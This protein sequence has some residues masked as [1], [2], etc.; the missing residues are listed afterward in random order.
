[1]CCFVISIA[2][3]CVVVSKIFRG[4]VCVCSDL[5]ISRR[6][7]ELYLSEYTEVPYDV[8]KFMISL[9]NYGGRIT[10]AMDAR[11]MIVI[12]QVCVCLFA[13]VCAV[14]V[15]HRVCDCVLCSAGLPGAG[16]VGS[17]RYVH[18][19]RIVPHPTRER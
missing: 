16:C 10:D 4:C 3:W 14:A 1:M 8:M 17:G 12:L 13:F 15:D 2:V 18:P 6:Q 5:Y 11:A 7:L 19:Q 9:I